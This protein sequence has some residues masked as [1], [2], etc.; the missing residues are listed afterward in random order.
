MSVSLHVNKMNYFNCI[1]F[2]FTHEVRIFYRIGSEAAKYSKEFPEILP[3][4]T[5]IGNLCESASAFKNYPVG[6]KRNTL[7]DHTFIAYSAGNISAMIKI[8]DVMKLTAQECLRKFPRFEIEFP[9]TVTVFNAY[10]INNF[11]FYIFMIKLKII[12]KK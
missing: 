1:F 4:D 2:Q 6:L 7:I 11:V 10:P 5:V 9:N 3:L 8:K 12:I